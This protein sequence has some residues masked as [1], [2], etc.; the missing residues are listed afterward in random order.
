M[1]FKKIFVL[2]LR[3]YIGVAE[4][5]CLFLKINISQY[6]Y[7]FANGLWYYYNCENS[8]EKYWNV[9]QNGKTEIAIC[10]SS[11]LSNAFGQCGN[12]K[13]KL[14]WIWVLNFSNL[15]MMSKVV[16]DFFLIY[17]QIYFFPKRNMIMYFPVYF[18]F[19]FLL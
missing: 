7:S 10:N 14:V 17:A 15:Q 3:K 13:Y 2:F 8:K 4:V 19:Y 11:I 9:I 18:T 12:K 16:F 6:Q 5:C 1:R